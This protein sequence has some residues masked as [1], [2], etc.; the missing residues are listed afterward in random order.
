MK[1]KSIFSA[2]SLLI[3]LSVLLSAC[4]PAVAAQF[5]QNTNAVP[6]AATVLPP[7]ET[8]AAPTPT[9]EPTLEPTASPTPD[10]RLDPEDWMNWP[11]VPEFSP[12]V[13]EIYKKGLELGNSPTA[14]S[15]IG[16]CQ[17]INEAFFGIYALEGRYG[18]PD[19]YAYLQDTIDYYAGMF[20]RISTAV[21]PGF[22]AP[23]ILSPLWADPSLCEQGE[24]PLEC[25]IRRN[26]PSVVLIG[27][28]FWFKGRSP[29]SYSQ[30]VRQIV[31]YAID[32]GVVPIVITKVDNVEGD[33]SINR[34]TA[35]I[36]YDYDIPLWNFWRAAQDLPDQGMDIER[37]DGFHIS[38][39]A[40]NERSF[41]GLQVLDAFRKAMEV[42][43]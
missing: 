33:N 14:F 37:N 5:P 30:Y 29:E 28:E 6:A 31:E 36:A 16:D 13:H 1:Q 38:V 15:K 2:L 7:T 11:V 40:W 26:K 32:H 42:N 35:Q 24:S 21:S 22:T 43:P 41:T 18:F 25:E 27:L 23:S 20:G 3:L 39:A 34:A 9:L 17:M 8:A 10:L 12:H 19:G 4:Q